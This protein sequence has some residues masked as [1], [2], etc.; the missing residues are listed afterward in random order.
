MT[1]EFEITLAAGAN[2]RSR[3]ILSRMGIYRF[4]AAHAA[5][6]GADRAGAAALTESGQ[7]DCHKD[8]PALSVPTNI[9]IAVVPRANSEFTK[10]WE[11]L[12]GK[13]SQLPAQ[14]VRRLT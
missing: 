12:L 1:R 14:L 9:Q 13:E 2:E 5:C 3:D 8:T 11:R 7:L 6:C 10:L 4:R